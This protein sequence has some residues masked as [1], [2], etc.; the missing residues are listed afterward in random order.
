MR[1]KTM[2]AAFVLVGALAGTGAKKSLKW[3]LN[4]KQELPMHGPSAR[5]SLNFLAQL[6]VESCLQ[7]AYASNRVFRVPGENACAT[8][9][10]LPSSPV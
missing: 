5:V 2:L 3:S 4:S 9:L 10:S 7:S 1:F 6:I 8:N